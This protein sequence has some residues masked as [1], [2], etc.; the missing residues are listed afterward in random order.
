MLETI[1]KLESRFEGMSVHSL[2]VAV[3][4]LLHDTVDYSNL[5]DNLHGYNHFKNLYLDS[6][7]TTLEE[8]LQT[9]DTESDN[10]ML[11]VIYSQMILNRRAIEQSLML[12]MQH[13]LKLKNTARL[14]LKHAVEKSKTNAELLQCAKYIEWE[15]NDKEWADEIRKK[16]YGED[17]TASGNEHS[18]IDGLVK[19]TSDFENFIKENESELMKYFSTKRPA[20]YEQFLKEEEKKRFNS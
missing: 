11:D 15:I 18:N 16:V 14:A 9:E 3:G 1:D 13:I 2:L 7:S 8:D 19:S 5:F 4:S 10:D 12:D 6:K 20:E 17:W